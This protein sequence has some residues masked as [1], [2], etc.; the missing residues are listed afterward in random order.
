MKSPRPWTA[1]LPKLRTSVAT[2][3]LPDSKATI[4]VLADQTT[5]SSVL[6]Q[7]LAMSVGPRYVISG[8]AE[9]EWNLNDS[10]AIYRSAT[11][12]GS[13]VSV[14]RIGPIDHIVDLRTLDDDEQVESVKHLIWH[15]R[16]GG[17]Y[18]VARNRGELGSRLA[19]VLNRLL[20]TDQSVNDDLRR[21]VGSFT[22]S[23]EH[24]TVTKANAHHLKLREANASWVLQS[25]ATPT[26]VRDLRTINGGKFSSAAEL[27]LHSAS[28][29]VDNLPTTIE[30]PTVKLRHY[31]GALHVVGHCL[32]H[33]DSEILPESFPRSF[34]ARLHNPKTRNSSWH[35]AEVLDGTLPTRHLDG[36]YYH[37]DAVN[38]GHFGHLMT[39]VVARLWGWQDAK[40]EFPDLKAIFRI[41]HPNEREPALEKLLFAAAG[42]PKED[43]VW[44]DEPV[45]VN[46]LVGAAPMFHNN[47]PHFVHPG[48]LE[49]WGRMTD[50]L[51]DPTVKDRH[52]KLF[53]SRR[54]GRKNRD[55]LN[56]AK[57]E[58]LFRDHGWH[59]LYPEDHALSYQATVF[60]AARMV[61]GF[62]G[63][64]LFNI[65]HTKQLERLIILNQ[66][67][68]TARN[69]HLYAVLKASEEHYFWSTPQVQHPAGGWSEEAYFSP[70]LFDFK[71][72]L[73]ELKP[74][75]D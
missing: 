71:R 61:A 20:A 28:A 15:L 47:V 32:V 45:T 34:S 24:I 63:S 8:V 4:V 73:A 65:M 1:A 69:E 13:I 68:Y 19:S 54:P 64:A 41:R 21:A 75:L 29:P 36:T 74:L 56:A 26:T 17:T 7:K 52:E 50:A 70:W 46:S 33:T 23:R 67:A 5:H 40:R 22:V 72:N 39:D 31:Q 14:I 16:R 3:I 55:C 25:R 2:A 27:H 48:I 60:S 11:S 12:L 43:I 42:I 58:K 18:C 35:F 38:A 62:G 66:E 57:V 30:Y 51:T 37:L 59:V 6:G 10:G 44:I 53:V 49:V 9:P